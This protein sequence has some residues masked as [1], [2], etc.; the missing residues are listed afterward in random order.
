MVFYKKNREKEG[1]E[2]G[3]YIYI[4]YVCIEKHM[5]NFPIIDCMEDNVF[6]ID[7]KLLE[8]ILIY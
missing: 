1:R 2:R 7:N 6:K 5:R 3:E 8:K 4:E